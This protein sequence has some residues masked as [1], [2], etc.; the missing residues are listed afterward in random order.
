MARPVVIVQRAIVDLRWFRVYYDDIFP[1]GL[2]RANAQIDKILRLLASYPK[3]GRPAGKSP[4]RQFSIP[5][6][7]FTIVYRDKG[8]VIEILRIL[9]QRSESYLKDL[10]ERS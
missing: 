1:E 9:D 5:N 8:D 10:F 4:R 6:I 7:P 3:M 2:S